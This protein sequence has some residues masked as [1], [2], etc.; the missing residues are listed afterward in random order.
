MKPEFSK[1][2]DLA[3][4]HSGAPF[5]GENGEAMRV[6]IWDRKH[7]THP[8]IAIEERGEQ[9]A[10]AFRA[11]GASDARESLGIV[12]N[13]VMLPLGLID[14]KPV[15]VGDDL[16]WEPSG[17]KVIATIALKHDYEWEGLRWPVPAKVY[18]KTRM[19]FEQLCGAGSM[20]LISTNSIGVRE[21][22]DAAL[23]HAV[24]AGQVIGAE[25]TAQAVR[26]AYADGQAIAYK[27]EAGGRS[28]RDTAIA[29]AV[30]SASLNVIAGGHFLGT[31][32]PAYRFANEVTEAIRRDVDLD[33]IIA[34]IK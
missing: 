19:T 27:H 33:S 20:S 34:K 1:P 30:L 22:A 21:L 11:N 12:R 24:N 14:G 28:A 10:V 4:A 5:S 2:F 29:K 23:R 17:K 6:L 26:Q 3:A 31:E 7:P 13:L 15:F 18:P 32:S 25:E 8:I 16:V 9:E